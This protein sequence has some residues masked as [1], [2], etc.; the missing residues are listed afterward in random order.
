MDRGKPSVLL[1]SISQADAIAGLLGACGVTVSV[2]L[3]LGAAAEAVAARPFDILILEL[4]THNH[5]TD[6]EMSW[7]RERSLDAAVIALGPAS[8][9][10]E[11]EAM[12]AGATDYLALPTSAEALAL[13]LKSALAHNADDQLASPLPVNDFGLLGNSQHIVA[14]RSTVASVA[15]GTATVLVR[16]ETGTGKELVARAV[17]AASAR[18]GA[19]FI[20]VHAA[21]LPDALLES[22]LF[23]YEKGAFTGANARKAGRVELAESGTLFFDEIGEV[24]PIMQA[25]LLRL[26]QDREYERLGGTQTLRANVRFIA[27]THRDL[28]HMVETG[29]FREDLFYRLNVVTIWLPPLRARRSDVGLIVR[30]YFEHFRAANGKPALELEDAA[31]RLLQAQRWPGNVRQLVNFIERAVVLAQGAAIT[32]SDVRRGLDEQIAFLTQAASQELAATPTPA[33]TPTPRAE[34][35]AQVAELATERDAPTSQRAAGETLHSSA[36]RPLKEEMRRTELRALKKALMSAK[37]N[38]ALAARMLG[39][40]RRTLYTKLEEHGIDEPK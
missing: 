38:R 1:I 28:E 11:R 8:S 16:G 23:G 9:E 14:V 20:K 3:D 26:L 10:L 27:A 2:S 13:A 35:V 32:A 15:S 18:S 21:A 36:V 33:P 22:E 6:R 24:S 29:G 40:S 34:N 31:V 7:I 25:K 39:V 30:S 37:G 4:G 17:H 5:L 12:A 19:P